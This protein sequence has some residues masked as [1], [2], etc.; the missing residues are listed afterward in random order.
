ME[1]DDGPDFEFTA[2]SEEM[3]LEISEE[4][5][6]Q[7]LAAAYHGINEYRKRKIWSSEMVIASCFKVR[8]PSSVAEIIVWLQ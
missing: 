3:Q 8:G 4:K 1:N 5:K 6:T 7:I 2:D